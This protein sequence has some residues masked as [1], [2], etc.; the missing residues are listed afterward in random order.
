[1]RPR[2]LRRLA[3]EDKRLKV[4][5][6][7]RNF[8]HIRRPIRNLQA[9]GDAAWRWPPIYRILQINSCVPCTMEEGYKAVMASN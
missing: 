5:L 9:S 3:A 4:I 7:A 6:N 1:M 8:G 2:I